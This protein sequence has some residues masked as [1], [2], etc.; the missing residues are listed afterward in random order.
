VRDFIDFVRR[1]ELL[2]PAAT[3]ESELRPLE[4]ALAAYD[5]SSKGQLVVLPEQYFRPQRRLSRWRTAQDD[6]DARE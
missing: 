3:S 2:L 6:R 5:S 4:I 1:R